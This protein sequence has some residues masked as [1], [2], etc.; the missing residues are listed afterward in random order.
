[1][2]YFKTALLL[3]MVAALNS[4]AQTKNFIINGNL[5]GMTK[6]PSKIYLKYDAVAGNKIDS[7]N[8][9]NGKYTFKGNIDASYVV[10]LNV[11]KDS[12]QG[13]EQLNIML[14][15]GTLDVASEGTLNNSIVTG[16]GAKANNEYL[17]VTRFAFNESAAIQ[18]IIQSEAYKTSDSLKQE[19]QKR[20]TSLLG[21]ALVNMINYV[22]KNPDSQAS[23]YFTYALIASGFV[24]PE[25]T[26][27]L[28]QAFPISL[29]SSKIGLAIDSIFNKRKDA[30]MEAATARKALE[31][32]VPLGSKAKDFTQNDVDGKPVSLSSFKGK[33]V[34]V[35]FWASWCKPCREENP[36][37]VNAFNKYKGK[38]FTILGVSFDNKTGKNAWIEAIKKD[39]LAWTQISALSGFENE[40]AVLYGIKSIPQNVLIDP[41]GVVVAKN[42]RG[43]ELQQK[44]ASIFNK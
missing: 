5:T 35:D 21:N 38:G 27:T 40:A 31:S 44:L 12:K 33:Y 8:V 34:L 14:D 30:Q 4:T 32:L 16:D 43:E 25:M 29:R 26:D 9:N 13:P 24:T 10:T 39:G 6:M 7:A 2:R 36:N 1:M 17:S 11:A 20:S 42:L 3:L 41:N 37:V 23:P 15:N 19:V 22:R 28:N 18:K